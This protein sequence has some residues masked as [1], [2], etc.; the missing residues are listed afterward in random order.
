MTEKT[1][2]VDQ[3]KSSTLDEISAM[4]DNISK[5]FKARHAIIAPIMA[6]LKVYQMTFTRIQLFS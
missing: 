4:V 1:A 3:L 5:E 2:E 6:E